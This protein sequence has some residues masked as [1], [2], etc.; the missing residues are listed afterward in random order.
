MVDTQDTGRV[1]K[2]DPPDTRDGLAQRIRA[3]SAMLR[4]PQR[5]QPSLP[6]PTRSPQPPPAA[7]A[8]QVDLRALRVQLENSLQRL[9]AGGLSPGSAAHGNAARCVPTLREDWA[10]KAVAH[11]MTRRRRAIARATLIRW[12]WVRQDSQV[13]VELEAK[14]EQ[15]QMELAAFR[16]PARTQV[17]IPSR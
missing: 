4:S 3:A 12:R 6:R 14:F 11:W 1:G 8:G 2:G 13:L 7:A 17:P 10:D 15:A 16:D 9:Q 5:R